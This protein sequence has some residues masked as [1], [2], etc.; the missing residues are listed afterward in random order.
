VV[1]C[2]SATDAN[3]GIDANIDANLVRAT[4]PRRTHKL[5]V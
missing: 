5:T 1:G 3:F 4:L 2:G